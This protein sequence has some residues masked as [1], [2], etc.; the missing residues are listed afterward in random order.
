MLLQ[1]I[2]RGVSACN[3]AHDA[4]IGFAVFPV[5]LPCLGR[6]CFTATW[7]ALS[8]LSFKENVTSFLMHLLC[9]PE[10]LH[11]CQSKSTEI[12]MTFQDPTYKV[13][14][15]SH[16]GTI[17]LCKNSISVNSCS[18]QGVK[19]LLLARRQS[20]LEKQRVLYLCA[21][22]LF[23][24]PVTWDVKYFGHYF[25]FII[26]T[27]CCLV[28]QLSGNH[29]NLEYRKL[30]DVWRMNAE[31]YVILSIHPWCGEDVH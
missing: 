19:I 12:C 5:T 24:L 21:N 15:F 14:T 25:S 3:L 29:V 23:C 4:L 18:Q 2:R 22:F 30:N 20:R 11:W 17:D 13:A 7:F 26:L 16:I 31:E 10:Q 9:G 28:M 6:F 8:S 1:G 27:E